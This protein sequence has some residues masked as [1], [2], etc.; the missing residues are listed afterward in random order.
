MCY[1]LSNEIKL[2]NKLIEIGNNSFSCSKIKGH[3][4]IPDSVTEM[5]EYC[6][7]QTHIE[8]LTLSVNLK[9]IPAYAFHK[10]H[11]LSSQIEFP[12]NLIEVGDCAFQYTQIHGSLVFP[13]YF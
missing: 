6:F 9:I 13:T 4:I 5:G 10:C 1:S 7:A 12:E 8:S 3:L 2:P 11:F